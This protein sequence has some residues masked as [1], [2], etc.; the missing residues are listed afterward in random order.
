[1][2][3]FDIDAHRQFL[4]T[5]VL[6]EY[7]ALG[8]LAFVHVQGSLVLGDTDESDLDVI[9]VWDA[10]EVPTGREPLV[11]RLDERRRAFPEVIDYRD[12]HI[13]RFVVG[14]QEYELAHYSLARFQQIME[15]VRTGSDLPGR[16]IVNPQAL[17]GA[18][19]EAVFVVDSREVGR[20]LQEMLRGFPVYLKASTR[21]A[22][23]NNRERR[24]N[25]LRTHARRG[26]W[27]PFH[28]ARA[29]ATR[30]V[31]QAIFAQREVHWT[32]DKW[33]RAAMVRYGFEPRLVEAF[34]RLWALDSSPERRL[35]AL[36]ELTD[37]ALADAPHGPAE[38][39]KPPR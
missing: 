34:D 28:S 35:A 13:D 33:R 16:E 4:V 1:M 29:S 2:S 37:A 20:R 11:A 9:L 21:L 18:F 10:S 36:D 25:E 32:G 26:D 30:T 22:A 6:P 31:L 39:G 23:S 38:Q 5:S 19:R 15:A 8:T 14:G 17:A 12:I 7:A 24:M 27:F 3:R